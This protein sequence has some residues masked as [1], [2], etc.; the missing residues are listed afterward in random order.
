M[1]DYMVTIDSDPELRCATLTFTKRGFLKPKPVAICQ[2]GAPI[3]D[4][5]LAQPADRLFVWTEKG[6]RAD[7]ESVICFCVSAGCE[8]WR[9]EE[10]GVGTYGGKII[11]HPE[12]KALDVGT[13]YGI[14]HAPYIVRLTYDG[15]EI[16]RY[17]ATCYDISHAAFRAEGAGDKSLARTQAEWAL[18]T[19][20]SPKTKAGLHRL[21]GDLATTDGEFDGAKRHYTNARRL[22]PELDLSEHLARLKA[23][24]MD[25]KTM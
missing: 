12:E 20:V 2:L 6:D 3:I 25:A 4:Y 21:L 14:P 17:P 19:Q 7:D 11:L 24:R 8:L 10:V 13:P 15:T 5:A 22:N 16:K 23:A 9:V 1:S 18:K